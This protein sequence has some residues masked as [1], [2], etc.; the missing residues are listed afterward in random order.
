MLYLVLAALVWGSSFPVI[1]Y[2][3]RDVS[4]ILFLILRFA[5]AFL[6]LLPRYRRVQRVRT[7]F[8]RDLVLIGF[9]T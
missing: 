8:G 3:L 2:T 7:L 9:S 6:I 4:P 5:V 1:Q